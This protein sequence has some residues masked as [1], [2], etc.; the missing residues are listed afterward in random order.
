MWVINVYLFKQIL[1]LNCFNKFTYNFF[2]MFSVEHIWQYLILYLFVIQDL[3][4]FCLTERIPSCWNEMKFSKFHHCVFDSFTAHFLLTSPF[5]ARHSRTYGIISSPHCQLCS[6]EC[7][8]ISP[9]FLGFGFK[10]ECLAPVSNNR[11]PCVQH[12][13]CSKLWTKWAS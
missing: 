2:K 7:R 12:Y 1:I 13:R 4:T 5:S 10:R 9:E 8:E 6:K 3:F 11:E